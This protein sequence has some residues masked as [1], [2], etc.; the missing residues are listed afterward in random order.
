MALSKVLAKE[1]TWEI[2]DG[3]DTS[4]FVEIG[5]LNSVS[6]SPSKNDAD[7]TTFD[8]DWVSH[9]VSTRGLEVALEGLY[10]EDASTGD[11]DAGQEQVEAAIAEVGSASIV[12]FQVT[13][14]GGT[15]IAFNASVNGEPFGMG[16]GGGND[17]ATSFSY[18]LTVSGKPTVS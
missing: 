4:T 12:P 1:F 11:R 16:G 5:G 15:V 18:T 8:E 7:T 14:P 6:L 10:M 3:T 2:D 17:D 9:L 13:S